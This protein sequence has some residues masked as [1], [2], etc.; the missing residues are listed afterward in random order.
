MFYVPFGSNFIVHPG[1][2]VL[3]STL[4]WVRVPETLGG[5][6]TGKSTISKRGLV[7]ETG[8]GATP[9]LF[10]LYHT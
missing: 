5:F 10:R 4:E 2:F 8:G 7:I 3:G 6:I 1:R 9:L